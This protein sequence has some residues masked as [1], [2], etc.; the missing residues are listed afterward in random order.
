MQR[1]N[2]FGAGQATPS[3]PRRNRCRR[4]P[5]SVIRCRRVTSPVPGARAWQL[6]YLSTSV[7]GAR[8]AVSGTVLVPTAV[9]PGIRPVVAYASG[10]QGW[11]DQCAPSREMAGRQL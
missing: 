4:P 6:L 2:L 5:G 11:G 1:S 9:H 8:M 7:S 3:T 10:T